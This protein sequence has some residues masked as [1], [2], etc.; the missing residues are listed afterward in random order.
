MAIAI[1][2]HAS[3]KTATVMVPTRA[4]FT[5]HIAVGCCQSAV[6]CRASKSAQPKVFRAFV[7]LKEQYL[8]AIGVFSHLYRLGELRK[9]L[10]IQIPFYN[11]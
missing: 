4:F 8:D 2:A 11:P 6:S 9:R 3:T 1:S 5:L 7:P 10:H